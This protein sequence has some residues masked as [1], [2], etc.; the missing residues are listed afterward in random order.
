V[1]LEFWRDRLR[2]F[3]VELIVRRRHGP[4]G[5]AEPRGDRAC[6]G[7]RSGGFDRAVHAYDHRPRP[8]LG[9]AG[10]PRDQHRAGR[11]AENPRGDG[12]EQERCG[13]PASVR[14]HGDQ[15]RALGLSLVQ[16][17]RDRVAVEKLGGRGGRDRLRLGEGRL[18]LVLHELGRVARGHSGVR[19]LREVRN[20][21]ERTLACSRCRRSA[22]RTATRLA[23]VPSTP[24]TMRSKTPVS[25]ARA[26][27]LGSTEPIP[28]RSR[29]LSYLRSSP[30]FARVSRMQLGRALETETERPLDRNVVVGEPGW[31]W[32]R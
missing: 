26:P 6:N 20:R 23:G 16:H 24:Q 27:I 12:A 2:R 7:E 17:D 14:P 11:V 15:R 21:Q 1:L 5:A 29:P 28:I 22:C 13:A 25:L 19:G 32:S 3:A 18:G 31:L 9:V 4:N 10:W 8:R 30:D